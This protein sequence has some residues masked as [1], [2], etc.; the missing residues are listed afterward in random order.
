MTSALDTR[1]A[2]CVVSS[3]IG[4]RREA[5][6]I[7]DEMDIFFIE[8]KMGTQPYCV[9]IDEAQS[10]FDVIMYMLLRIVDELDV[11][12]MAFGLKMIFEMN[13][14]KVPNICSYWLIN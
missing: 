1:D 3:R 5:V 10:V 8:K 2:F 14:L 11:P 12:V 13:C 4:M 9:L 6:T 7:D